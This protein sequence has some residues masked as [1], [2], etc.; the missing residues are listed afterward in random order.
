[1]NRSILKRRS[2][3]KVRKEFELPLTSMMDMLIIL[4]VFLLKSYSTSAVAFSTSS[5]IALPTSATPEAPTEGMNLMVEPAHVTMKNGKPELE[6]GAII[7]EGQKVIEFTDQP[8]IL[9]P[10]KP[11]EPPTVDQ[12]GVK[13]AL[14]PQ[15]VGDDGRRILPLFDALTKEKEKV[16]YIHKTQKFVDANGQPTEPKPFNGTLFIH[17]DKAVQYQLLRKIMYTA[18]AAEFRIFKLITARKEET[19]AP[20]PDAPKK[21]T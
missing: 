10:T 8:Q 17:A 3:K 11:D 19:S 18:A 20:P 9:P 21:G 2:R 16:E 6:L 1:M 5:N 4:L 15:L 12:A 13:Y 7:L 14:Q